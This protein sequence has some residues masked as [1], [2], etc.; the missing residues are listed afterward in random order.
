MTLSDITAR[1]T[2]SVQRDDLVSLYPSFV[3]EALTEIQRRRSWLCMKNL[4]FFSILNGNSSVSLATD[5]NNDTT[6]FKELT[7]GNSPV[8]LQGEDLIFTPCDVWTREKVLRRQARLIS[9]SILYTIYSHPDQSRRVSVPVWIG[10]E[11]EQPTL[12]ILFS[13]ASNLPFQVSYYGYLPPL[14]NPTDSNYLTI[15][16]P[17]MVVNKAKAIAFSTIQDPVAANIEDFFEKKFREAV[18]QDAYQQ[19]AGLELRF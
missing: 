9:N 15:N 19:V 4:S 12:N 1:L 3:N 6:Y 13:A 14:V 2:A 17:E 10:W 8:Q 11:N 16:Y 5:D 7:I 18:A